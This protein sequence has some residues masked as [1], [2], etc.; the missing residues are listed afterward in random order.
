M[1]PKKKKA[2]KM[3]KITIFLHCCVKLF[4]KWKNACVKKKNVCSITYNKFF[5]KLCLVRMCFLWLKTLCKSPERHCYS[6]R[7]R[8]D[9]K[10]LVFS[11]KVP[12]PCEC[13]LVPWIGKHSTWHLTHP[14]L[15]NLYLSHSTRKKYPMLMK[16][17]FNSLSSNSHKCSMCRCASFD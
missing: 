9:P 16:N 14:I 7:V 5:K 6:Y 4:L 13:P 15:I 11:D 8:A 17:D 2:D 1:A 10:W 12:F 3:P